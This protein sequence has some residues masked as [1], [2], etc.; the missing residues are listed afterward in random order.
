MDTE[1][2]RDQI[3]H[4][5]QRLIQQR[6]CNAFSYRDLAEQIGIKTSSIHYYFPQK[7]DL[8]LAAMQTYHAQWRTGI[9]AIDTGLP[10]SAQLHAYLQRRRRL[11]SET[12][13]VCLGGA[14]AADLA[15]LPQV[16]RAEVQAYYRSNEAWLTRVL[17]LGAQDSSLAY[18]GDARLAAQ[19]LFAALQGS[20]FGA[21]LFGTEARLADLVPGIANLHA[22]EPGVADAYGSS[23]TGR[24][25][26]AA[27]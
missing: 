23:A 25:P 5:A 12:D 10:A 15:S 14:L 4:L 18:T 26:R 8:L 9:A 21:R 19:A 1:T 22:T 16:V 6:G 7:E 27:A 2:T 20:L 3:V 13:R 11:F 24:R 17:L